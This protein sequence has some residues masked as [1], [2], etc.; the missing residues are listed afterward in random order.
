MLTIADALVIYGEP[1]SHEHREVSWLL[2][3]IVGINA[4]TLKYKSEQDLTEQQQKQFLQGIERLKSGEPLAY[5]IGEQDFWTLT[6]KVTPDTLIPRP[7]TEILVEQALS[8]IDA[9]QPFDI[10]DLGTGSGAIALSLAKERPL[11]Q[12]VASDFSQAALVVAQANAIKNKIANVSFLQGSWFSALSAQSI[13]QQFDLIVSNPPYIDAVDG[14]LLD[15][16]HEPITALVADQH[17]LADLQH[18]I[19][20]AAHWLK[21][22]GWL[23]LEHGYDQGAAV[24]DILLQSGYQQ[25]KTVQDYGGNDRVSMGQR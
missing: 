17:G 1:D 11:S 13:D 6:L 24:R 10:L 15:L 16:S 3:H 18:I 20:H 2:E 21:P 19:Q 5:I 7:D 23:L 4:L 9:A 22:S 14:H 25:V 8:L 12:V